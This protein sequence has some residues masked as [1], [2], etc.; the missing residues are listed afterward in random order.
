MLG[1]LLLKVYDLTTFLHKCHQY[2]IIVF[3]QEC[4]TTS[5]YISA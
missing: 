1:N 5:M 3:L 2:M 4:P